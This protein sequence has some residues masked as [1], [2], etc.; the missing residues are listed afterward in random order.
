MVLGYLHEETMDKPKSFG[1]GFMRLWRTQNTIVELWLSAFPNHHKSDV[2][3]E[4][5][6]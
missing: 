5:G 4:S 3:D 1:L 2:T 6:L